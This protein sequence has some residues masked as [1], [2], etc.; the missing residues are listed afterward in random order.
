M[1]SRPS[2]QEDALSALR[3]IHPSTHTHTGVDAQAVLDGAEAGAVV[4]GGVLLVGR[5]DDHL[6]LLQ[7]QPV[8]DLWRL[9]VAIIT[10]QVNET[11][12]SK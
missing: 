12:W 4:L 8:L 9:K 6:H 5:V 1:I 10:S 2:I 3:D 7:P 11:D